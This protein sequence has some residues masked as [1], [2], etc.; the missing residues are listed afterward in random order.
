MV[1]QYIFSM[2]DTVGELTLDL[3]IWVSIRYL[4]NN[5]LNASWSGLSSFKD[6]LYKDHVL[7]SQVFNKFDVK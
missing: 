4:Q 6:N 1:Y 5:N 7:S 2:E 3:D